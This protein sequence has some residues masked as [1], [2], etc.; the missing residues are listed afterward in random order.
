ME[1]CG[2]TPGR[3]VGILKKRIEEAILDGIIS[4]EYEE[5]KQYLYQIKDEVLGAR[6]GN[7]TGKEKS[8]AL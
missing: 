5:A 4:N 1:I 3:T 8:P 2:L 7:E 6:N